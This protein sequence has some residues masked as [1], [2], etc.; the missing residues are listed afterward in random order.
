MVT[1]IG[2]ATWSMTAQRHRILPTPRI[3]GH[4]HAVPSSPKNGSDPSF[5]LNNVLS[6]PSASQEGKGASGPTLGV[7]E[8]DS[9][10]QFISVK[11][12][13]HNTYTH[14]SLSRET[15]E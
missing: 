2:E 1:R 12:L 11:C 6:L 9:F 10:F 14:S 13:H 15:A 4:M 7:Y 5:T 3:P 8:V